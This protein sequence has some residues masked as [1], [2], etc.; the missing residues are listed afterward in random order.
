MNPLLRTIQ[1][2]NYNFSQYPIN[3]DNFFSYDNPKIASF[4][5]FFSLEASSL[6][7]YRGVPIMI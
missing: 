4:Q 3:I 2:C 1:Y 6:K 5:I 7:K